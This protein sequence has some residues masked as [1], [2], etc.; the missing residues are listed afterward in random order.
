MNKII[1][2]TA[3]AALAGSAFAQLHPVPPPSSTDGVNVDSIGANAGLTH[4]ENTSSLGAYRF[5]TDD[6]LGTPNMGSPDNILGLSWSSN[7]NSNVTSFMN[8]INTQ[9]GSLLI[10]FVG[11]SQGWHGDAG[12]TRSGDAQDLSNSFSIFNNIQAAGPTPN[13]AFGDNV[14]IQLNPGEASSF[15]IWANG[16]GQMGDANPFPTA[17][18]GYYT[19]FHST[20]SVPFISPG[21]VRW[22]T[23]PLMVNTWVPALNAYADVGTYLVGFEDWRLDRGADRDFNDLLLAIQFYSV[24]GTPFTPPVPEPSTYGLIGAAALLGLA[25]YRRSRGKK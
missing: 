4:W 24:T 10:A 20:N 19:A 16:T 3:F 7:V 21:N 23:S 5:A 15:D 2:L 1:A 25:A 8:T 9:G 17:D 22:A 13:V 18:G 6:N 14:R 12:Y 11:E